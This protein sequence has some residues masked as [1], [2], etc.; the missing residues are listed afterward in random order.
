MMRV[1]LFCGCRGDRTCIHGISSETFST[2]AIHLT[3][4]LLGYEH[5]PQAR[6]P[7]LR[8]R[9]LS[10]WIARMQTPGAVV[11]RRRRGIIR[12]EEHFQ[13]FA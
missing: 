12:T 9:V 1:T 3:N 5:G 10:R 11:A 4:C 13:T 6:H 2:L 7:P 8:W